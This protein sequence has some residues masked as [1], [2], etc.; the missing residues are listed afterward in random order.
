M[1]MTVQTQMV[2]AEQIQNSNSRNNSKNRKK[3]KNSYSCNCNSTIVMMTMGLCKMSR[4]DHHQEEQELLL[5][6]VITTIIKL[7]LIVLVAIIL[8]VIIVIDN[9]YES[10]TKVQI[11]LSHNWSSAFDATSDTRKWFYDWA[12][13]NKRHLPI[14]NKRPIANVPSGLRSSR[15]EKV[16]E[17]P[18]M[19]LRYRHLHEVVWIC[20]AGRL[21]NRCKSLRNYRTSYPLAKRLIRNCRICSFSSNNANSNNISIL[22]MDI[23]STHLSITLVGEIAALMPTAS[24][25]TSPSL[26]THTLSMVRHWPMRLL[27]L[28]SLPLPRII[29]IFNTN[30]SN[31][32]SKRV[33]LAGPT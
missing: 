16:I 14:M 12:A 27:P 18:S 4:Q 15:S 13:F 31:S 30:S 28:Y 29:P 9:V 7:I 8:L 22:P 23:N 26:I 5:L 17:P 19:P 24:M 6:I 32:S 1:Q 25:A 20:H 21:R 33:M 2:K 3:E 10:E 11:S